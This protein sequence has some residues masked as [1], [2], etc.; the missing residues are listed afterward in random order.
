MAEPVF[1]VIHF[2]FIQIDVVQAKDIHEAK[3]VALNIANSVLF[4]AAVFGENP[5]V[6]RV[7]Q[8]VGASGIK[9]K[10]GGLKI[11]LGSLKGRQVKLAINLSR[12][13]AKARVFT[14][15]LTPEYIK[16]NAEYN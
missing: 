7:A 5:N 2:K 14:S 13:K 8:A 11:K 12:G 16:I 15:D 6:G 9:I 10:E 3:L 1:V 4:K